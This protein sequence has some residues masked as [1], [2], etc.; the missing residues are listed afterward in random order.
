MLVI[1]IIGNETTAHE[2]NGCPVLNVCKDVNLSVLNFF[3]G[4]PLFKKPMYRQRYT[5]LRLTDFTQSITGYE[6]NHWGLH[7]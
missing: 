7:D 2:S 4:N 1:I 5:L 3:K 6:P